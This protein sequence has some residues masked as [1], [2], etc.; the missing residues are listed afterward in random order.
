VAQSVP[1]PPPSPPP[2][3]PPPYHPSSRSHTHI[4]LPCWQASCVLDAW[5]REEA[6]AAARTAKCQERCLGDAARLT[7]LGRLI[8]DPDNFQRSR[9]QHSLYVTVAVC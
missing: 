4:L 8:V 5:L 9:R 6:A 1:S 3:P 2:N 7:R